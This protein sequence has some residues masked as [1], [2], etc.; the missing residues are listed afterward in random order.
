MSLTKDDLYVVAIGASAGGLAA[1]ENFFDNTP[2]NGAA[3][4]VVQHLYE[5]FNSN[6]AELL[7][8]HSSLEVCEAGHDMPV[9]AGKVY[10]ITSKDCMS[11]VKGRL[12][13]SKKKQK[14]SPHR[15]IDIFLKS[16]ALDQGYRSVGIIL[17]GL[18]NDGV[19][20]IE[21]IKEAGGMVMVQT[22]LTALYP[23]MPG[24]AVG[25]GKADAVLPAEAMP[26]ALS[27]YMKN[28][29][30]G[31]LTLPFLTSKKQNLKPILEH[32]KEHYPVDFTDYKPSTIGRRVERRMAANR[33][34]SPEEYLDF[35]RKNPSEMELL[36]KDFLI[37]VTDFFRDKEAFKIIEK[38]LIPD[39]LK[40][41]RDSFRAWVAGCASG[42]EAYSLAMLVTEHAS[43]NNKKVNI[44]IFA[45]DIE[46]EALDFAGKGIYSKAEVRNV[47]AYFLGKYF[48]EIGGKYRVIQVIRDT[49]I[50][51]HHDLT[52]NPPYCQMDIVCCRNVLIYMK[53]A[54]QKK[55]HTMLHFGLK[56][57][58]FLVLGP[59]EN[60]ESLKPYFDDV[61]KKW[62]IY[63]KNGNRLTP[64]FQT[65][66]PQI[67]R[68]SSL[69][70]SI[71]MAAKMPLPL[72]QPVDDMSGKIL[73]G[74]GYSGV[75]ADADLRVAKSFGNVGKF[76]EPKLLTLHLK[77]LLPT[78]LAVAVGNA[79]KKAVKHNKKI[80]QQAVPLRKEE[81]VI[82]LD[83]VVI[84][85]E[86]NKDG[87]K[88]FA[89]LFNERD[90]AKTSEPPERFDF[91]FHAKELLAETEMELRLL[92]ANLAEAYD[93]I[94]ASNEHL[95]S[96]NEELL[97]ANEEMQSAN[98]EMR[99]VNEELQTISS[100][101]L[102]KIREL[103]ELNDDLDNYFRSNVNGQIFIDGKLVL[104]KFSS[105]ASNYIN[106]QDSDIGR[107]FS[108]ITT[109][110]RFQTLMEDIIQVCADGR[111]ITKEAESTRGGWFQV[112]IMPYVRR[113][114]KRQD[115]V[116][117]TF[118]DITSLK[119]A[120]EE[121]VLSNQSLLRI[122]EDLHNFV[123]TA[124]HDLTGPLANIE[125]TVDVL[126]ET[127][128]G[129]GP[130][131][132]MHMGILKKSV[133]NFRNVIKE[134]SDIAR[135]E[136]EILNEP[137][138]IAIDELLEEVRLSIVDKIV[139][140]A[141]NIR[142]DLNVEHVRFS[143]KNLRSIL[144]NLLSNAIKFR[145]AGRPL[146]I[147]I[148]TSSV[149]N[150]VLLT[151]ADNGSGM[152]GDQLEK[153]FQLYHRATS[154]VEGSGVGLYLVKKIIDSSGGKVEVE[155]ELRK[156][157]TFKLYFKK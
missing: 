92:K 104:R 6:L 73:N 39:I 153:I 112:M 52:T 147:S 74:L 80:V 18:G 124:S 146:Q 118:N 131:T 127:M 114:D 108:H 136:R 54:L 2:P 58:G 133:L 143:R 42:E 84:P 110:I 62:N 121:L 140:S 24:N 40:K 144:Y 27:D 117:V 22:P 5:H 139:D 38:K 9:Q 59:S 134:L 64:Q 17:S 119:K 106:L 99:S 30:R 85:L 77:E 137:D 98:E 91:Q 71:G 87:L 50:F 69:P 86:S 12:R 82:L 72:S 154:R 135:I 13:L 83:L 109:N 132:K 138:L 88:S 89:I 57:D 19:E 78:T 37:G 46:K 100:E 65:I 152:A 142:T 126:Q 115:G 95:H 105:P 41:N 148:R 129:V 36:A 23:D 53:P 67:A 29:S 61:N 34:A 31:P 48:I 44:K 111:V 20:G 149:P 81:K 101:R 55:I 26:Q 116:I 4:I 79:V 97:S 145:S 76:L 107:P 32:L 157:T 141:A 103:T 25:S 122:N 90:D 3:Y 68:V 51:A 16:L 156:G 14:T 123:Y 60:L 130:E 35:L 102:Q 8:K 155:S 47:P 93:K 96:F 75:I 94:E 15:T 21:A 150:F 33:F 10:V 66:A 113:E 125:I 151:I 1:L 43:M 28:L 120:Q 49:V 63:R 45:T 128:S 11:I 70:A 7:S 56:P